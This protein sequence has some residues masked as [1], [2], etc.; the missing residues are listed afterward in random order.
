MKLLVKE[1]LLRLEPKPLLRNQMSGLLIQPH[2]AEDL[3]Q[4]LQMAM[5]LMAQP[6]VDAVATRAGSSSTDK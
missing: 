4:V 6:I 5:Q 3:S 2:P 1:F